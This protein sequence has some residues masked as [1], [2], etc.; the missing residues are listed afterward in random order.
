MSEFT[1]EDRNRMYQELTEREP[2]FENAIDGNK[3]VAFDR[4]EARW[5]DKSEIVDFSVEL[6]GKKVGMTKCLKCLP[7]DVIARNIKV[8]GSMQLLSAARIIKLAGSIIRVDVEKRIV[9]I[10]N[11]NLIGRG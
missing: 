8:M 5:V 7:G 1:A 10:Q 2:E 11:A 4:D 9:K 6:N 3:V